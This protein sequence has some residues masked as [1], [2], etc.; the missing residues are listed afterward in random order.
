MSPF[1]WSLSSVCEVASVG[2]TACKVVAVRHVGH[3][4]VLYLA[5]TGTLFDTL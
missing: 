2:M 3:V 1:S 5:L 4:G